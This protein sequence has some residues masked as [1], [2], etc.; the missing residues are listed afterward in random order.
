MW[1]PTT[2]CYGDVSLLCTAW[3]LR[4]NCHSAVILG[5]VDLLTHLLGQLALL[6]CYCV[7]VSPE[8]KGLPYMVV[9]LWRPNGICCC[10][11]VVSQGSVCMW[12]YGFTWNA[13]LTI[14]LCCIYV[15]VYVCTIFDWTLM[16]CNVSA[17]SSF[18]ALSPFDE[19]RWYRLRNVLEDF[20]F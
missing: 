12:G 3:E 16:W 17:S 18:Y 7:C 20:I 9:P 8:V 14:P 19:T 15:Y 5:N 13:A 4:C 2:Y 6:P 11:N 1:Y 10:G